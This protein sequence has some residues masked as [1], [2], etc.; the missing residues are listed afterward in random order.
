MFSRAVT[1]KRALLFIIIIFVATPCS[2]S[3]SN[4]LLLEDISVCITL[5]E[6]TLE[7]SPSTFIITAQPLTDNI[8]I[9]EE[10]FVLN[11]IGAYAAWRLTYRVENLSPDQTMTNIIVHDN[12]GDELDIIAYH[13]E[14]SQGVTP[15]SIEVWT[16]GQMNKYF[17]SWEGFSL[18][19]GQWGLLTIDI[20]TGKNPAGKQEYTSCG[21]YNLNSQ[22][23]LWYETDNHKRTEVKGPQFKVKIPCVPYISIDLSGT[24]ISWFVRKPGDYFTKAAEGSVTAS[25]PIVVTFSSFDDLSN[26]NTTDR[27]PIFYALNTEEPSQWIP[28]MDLNSTELTLNTSDNTVNFNIWQRIVVEGQG[29][30]TYTNRGVITFTLQ[31]MEI[32]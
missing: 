11:K 5:L 9:I 19:P 3:Y 32:P 10:D 18:S 25:Y 26:E 28:A 4:P 16:R 14:Y 27:I 22:N 12:F 29:V 15:G 8:E 23:T 30:N 24:Y 20:A 2:I 31:N 21:I 17:L 13:D 1:L 7:T 6:T